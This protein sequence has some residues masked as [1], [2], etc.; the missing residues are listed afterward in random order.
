MSYH[1]S[2]NEYKHFIGSIVG[3]HRIEKIESYLDKLYIMTDG[4]A[5]NAYLLT[6]DNGE[7]FNFRSFQKVIDKYGSLKKIEKE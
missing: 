2:N 3:P 7:T 1:F 5:G 6:L 4:Y